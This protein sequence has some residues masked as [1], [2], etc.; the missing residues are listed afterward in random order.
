MAAALGT[1]RCHHE[2]SKSR[3]SRSRADNSTASSLVPPCSRGV[4]LAPGVGRASSGHRL[5]VT[6]PPL[7]HTDAPRRRLGYQPA[8][9]GLRAVA[10]AI[11]LVVHLDPD[12]LPGGTHAVDV[13]FVLSG[14][15]ITTLLVEEWTQHG[16]V[17]VRAF[18]MRRVWRLGPAL[19]VFAP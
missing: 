11:V 4:D 18:W 17:D 6:A 9:D 3:S 15:L 14:F 7:L 2:R 16:A 8:L 5:D 1:A 19:A 12:A 13:F 10:F